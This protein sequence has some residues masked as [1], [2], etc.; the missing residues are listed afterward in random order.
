MMILA[1]NYKG[2]GCSSTVHMLKQL[3]KKFQP[4]FIFVPKTL[5]TI[6]QVKKL[7]SS[8]GYYHLCG[9][10]PKGHNGGFIGAWQDDFHVNPIQVTKHW[11][12]LHVEQGQ[13]SKWFLT[14]ICGPPKLAER[15][16]LWEFIKTTSKQ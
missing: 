4:Q 13:D 9:V 2:L 14:G 5:V 11:I 8:F 1:W 12:H 7:I 16:V 10:N 6:D 15:L 3:I